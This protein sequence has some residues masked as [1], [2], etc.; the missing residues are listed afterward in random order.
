MGIWQ[1]LRGVEDRQEGGSYS[2]A[3]VALI[4]SQAGGAS[5][6]PG[7]TAALESCSGFVSRSFASADVT[8]A[9]STMAGIL[10]P[11]T[12]SVIGRALIRQGE[13]L[14]V[15]Q[16]GMESDTPRLATAASWTVVGGADPKGWVYQVSLAGPS[17]QTAIVVPAAGVIHV[18]Y[19]SDPTAMHR[20]VGPLQ[21]A[22]LAGRLSA[23]VSTALADELSGPRGSL[24]PLPHVDGSDPAIDSLK[25]D[26]RGLSGGLAFVES[27]QD[28]FGSGPTTNP[29]QGWTTQRIGAA[30][31]DSSIAAAKMAFAEVCSACGLSVA[32]WDTSPGSA[33]REAF[34]QAM[35]S[36]LIPLGRLVSSELTAKLETDVQLDWTALGAGDIAGRARAFGSL[37]TGGMDVAKA[38]A[39][40]GLMVSDPDD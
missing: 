7:A 14:A 8:T 20:G 33:S 3:L 37:V 12:L 5:A 26:I 38:A 30:L 22:R 15:I 6:L 35:H 10:D 31:P 39:L 13:F 17:A 18:R 24:L 25:A 19:T 4:Q 23:E 2:D 36:V 27:Q 9:D 29:S 40:S 21:S 1:R 28:S 16:M 11:H 32:L 34:R